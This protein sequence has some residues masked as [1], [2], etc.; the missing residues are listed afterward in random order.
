MRT[1]ACFRGKLKNSR[2]YHS[3]KNKKIRDRVDSRVDLPQVVYLCSSLRKSNKGTVD[4]EAQ[5][6]GLL[7]A[8]HSSTFPST[9]IH[10]P[11]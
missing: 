1:S 7:V 6:N 8:L 3:S 4:M 9:T 2:R 11:P 10:C 5:G